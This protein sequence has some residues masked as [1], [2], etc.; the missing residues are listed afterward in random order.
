M[1]AHLL[2]ECGLD[3]G[4]PDELFAASPDNPDGYWEHKRFVELNDE[5]LNVLGGGWDQPPEFA[6]DWQD[7]DLLAPLRTEAARIIAL[8]STAPHWGWKDP[9]NCLTLSFWN[10][11][12]PD[13]KVVACVRNPMDVATSLRRRGK[14]SYGFG[15][16]LWRTYNERLLANASPGQRILVHYNSLFQDV[17]GEL[18]RIAEFLQ[19]PTGEEEFHRAAAVA[20][21]NLRHHSFTIDDLVE[22]NVAPAIIDLY[23][24]LCEESGC[25]E[26]REVQTAP[27]AR[28]DAARG[29]EG[30]RAPAVPA[31]VAASANIDHRR[32]P[33]T[34]SGNGA[35]RHQRLRPL[36][37]AVIENSELREQLTCLR[38]RLQALHEQFARQAEDLAELQSDR[39][40]DVRELQLAVEEIWAAPPSNE[41]GDTSTASRVRYVQTIRRFREAVRRHV[42]RK[43]SILVVSR[44]DEE[45]LKLYDRQ[46]EHFPQ[47]EGGRYSG[48]YPHCSLS[49]VAH[50]ETLR[51][52]GAE[53][54]IF[55][56]TALWW[57]EK[58]PDFHRHLQRQ[59]RCL[60]HNCDIGA[61][62]SL[63]QPNCWIALTEAAAECRLR[64]GREASLLN[65][66]SGL[67]LAYSF[68]EASV[69]SPPDLSAQALPYLDKS[70]D[71][72][73]LP[74]EN[75][76]LIA[77]ARRVAT[78]AVLL[79]GRDF[80]CTVEWLSDAPADFP[81]VSI[82]I[83][84][85]N[86]AAT[87]AACLTSL[88]ETL[89]DSFRGEI[90][91]VD[92]AS[93]DDTPALLDGWKARDARLRFLR[94]DLNQ[95]FLETA[96]RGAA[97]A[98]GEILLFLN[99]DTVLLPDW[100]PPLLRVFRDFP[101]AGAVGGKLLFADGALQEAGGMVFCDGSAANF[102][103]GDH[104]VDAPQYNVVREVDYC[105]GA[106]LATRRA[107]FEQ[108]GGFDDRYRPAYYEDADYCFAVRQRGFRVYY[109]PECA[110]VHLEGASSGTDLSRGVKQYQV[111]NQA[112]FAEKWS[113]ALSRQ[114]P[115][116]S[117]H[118]RTAWLTVAL[119]RAK[120]EGELS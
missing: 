17:R 99:N 72:I 117:D 100:L 111:L 40:R 97:V 8:F 95:G 22:A 66:N 44:G 78:Q 84:V 115:R 12:L 104:D 118:D 63:R 90:I 5:V 108:I 77:E 33:E 57:L 120:Q 49:A 59:Y 43:S 65:W 53:Y 41:P 109:Q 52:Q 110:V 46:A 4:A 29:L 24:R 28:Q 10:E 6:L 27:H 76:E 7:D 82:V 1:L 80:D 98:Q 112:K 119:G 11:L 15:L 68:P 81:S 102:G 87:T 47:I 31:I 42:P 96:R 55:P 67:N 54:L 105:S 58:Y 86:H 94:N 25:S 23:A 45:L 71:L 69:F 73:A 20:K 36:N 103:R 62:F 21:P 79:I 85:Y 91:V 114:A 18:R 75:E 89:P 14:S 64:L 30:V 83:P 106:L 101:Q 56:Q 50:L 37:L 60:L 9:R 2:R 32:E 92:D 38:D 34:H 13:L 39:E 116:P 51:V 93:S 113:G 35:A 26:S 107:L 19:L 61:V 74:A 16:T 3:L 48:Y 88:V 70:I